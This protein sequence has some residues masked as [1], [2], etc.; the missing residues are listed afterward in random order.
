MEHSGHVPACL[1]VPESVR[2]SLTNSETPRTSIH[3]PD[4]IKDV[5]KFTARGEALVHEQ[6]GNT[7]YYA[8][9]AN[10]LTESLIQDPGT[11]NIQACTS[12][13]N[14]ARDLCGSKNVEPKILDVLD[15]REMYLSNFSKS[16]SFI[17][18]KQN[19]ID[20]NSSIESLSYEQPSN[21]AKKLPREAGSIISNSSNQ[22]R[23]RSAKAAE[24]PWGKCSY[25]ELIVMALQSSPTSCMTLAQIYDWIVNNV[26]YFKD[27]GCYLSIT[28][29]KVGIAYNLV[30]INTPF[31]SR[32][33]LPR[34]YGIILHYQ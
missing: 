34:K 22:Q 15:N 27:K 24:K 2:F 17:R 5:N 31:F 30:I 1:L 16:R 13:C 32:F 19:F 26:P 28:G 3:F 6:L 10:G 9:K 29:W 4:S 11:V 33:L 14:R 25:S 12:P 23:K 20:R 21:N 7:Q 8:S 18:E